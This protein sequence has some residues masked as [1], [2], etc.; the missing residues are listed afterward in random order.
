MVK[1]KQ[2]GGAR[3]GAGRK[4]CS[5]C[6]PCK[7]IS[8]KISLEKEIEAKQEIKSLIK[9]KYSHVENIKSNQ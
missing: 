5:N 1:Q 9:K 8:F 7:I 3:P 2:S 6:L 4:K